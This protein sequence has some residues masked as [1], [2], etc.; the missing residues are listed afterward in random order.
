MVLGALASA[1]LLAVLALGNAVGV[2][3]FLPFELFEKLIRI[4]PGRIITSGIDLMVAAITALGIHPTSVAAKL[5]E[6]ASAVGLFVV[7][8]VVLAV[9][10]AA[11][12]GV[13]RRRAWIAGVS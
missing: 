2:V 8:C 7:V 1:L 6:Q 13:S 3:P 12:G 10:V 11:I 9:V 4:L 5:A